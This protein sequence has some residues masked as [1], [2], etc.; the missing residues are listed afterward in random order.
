MAETSIVITAKDKYSNTLKNMAKVTKSFSKDADEMEGILGEIDRKKYEMKVE[1]ENAKKALKEA[2]RAYR[3]SA[4]SAEAFQ[5]VL[6]RGNAYETAKRNLEAVTKEGKNAEKQLQNITSELSKMENRAGDRGI[7]GRMG[8]AAGALGIGK[9]MGD[10]LGEIGK[11]LTGSLWGE[12]A[13]NAVNSIVS[14]AIN[15]GGAGFAINGLAGAAFGAG[16]GTL[17]GIGQA[18]TESFANKDEAF[19]SVVN[20][21]YEETKQESAETLARGIVEAGKRETDQLSF[22][23]LLGS[24]EKAEKLLADITKFGNETPFERNELVEMSK[25]LLSYGYAQENILPALKAVGDAG[26]ALGHSADDMGWIA[27]YLGRLHAGGPATLEDFNVFGD[28]A[29]NLMEWIA[30][31]QGIS[32]EQVRKNVSQGMYD[33]KYVEDVFLRNAQ[34]KYGGMMDV[35]SGTY[36]GMQSTLDDWQTEVDAARGAGFTEERKKGMEKEIAWTESAGAAG[37]L[38]ANEYI[39]MFEASLENKREELK[40]AAFDAIEMGIVDESLWSKEETRE[41]LKELNERFMELKKEEENGNVEAGAEIGRLYEEAKIIAAAEYN[42]TEG[43]KLWA[44]SEKTL[45]ENIRSDLSVREE[46][47]NAG[48]ELGMEMN[49]GLVAAIKDEVVKKAVKGKAGAG[50]A[51]VEEY[52]EESEKEES[53]PGFAYGISYVPYNRFPAV[54]HEGERVLTANQARQMDMSSGAYGVN[55]TV[56]G[57]TVRE[58]ADVD[59][60]AKELY[61]R[62]ALAQVIGV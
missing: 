50:F 16:V 12:N 57:L 30:E 21:L 35:Q 23:T 17:L 36:N 19:K 44:E 41:R 32:Y 52:M 58:E 4:G 25:T 9:M 53:K 10:N 39:G 54:L 55:I 49:K 33:G 6:K 26:A 13:G 24:A 37:M 60:I 5:E 14:N 48:Y 18:A 31:E 1:V 62:L 7:L 29:V 42:A 59:R 40:R 61:R 22:T 3:D 45:M 51:E 46:Y 15:M 20:Q 11:T 27:T 56:E 47:W 34:E 2:E 38:A 8:K 28:R 43:A